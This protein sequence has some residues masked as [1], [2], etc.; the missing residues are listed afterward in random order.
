[1][2]HKTEALVTN[3]QT[4]VTYYYWWDSGTVDSTYLLFFFLIY[5][6]LKSNIDELANCIVTIVGVIDTGIREPG[7][8]HYRIRHVRLLELLMN[9][10]HHFICM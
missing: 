9:V 7:F 4:T 5:T 10:L 8:Y 3:I 1:M 2:L 6:Y